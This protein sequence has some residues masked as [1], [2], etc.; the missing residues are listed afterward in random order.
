[1]PS[2]V[3][4]LGCDTVLIYRTWVRWPE[5]TILANLVSPLSTLQ[6][7]LSHQLR[8]VCPLQHTRS[9]QYHCLNSLPATTTE[10]SWLTWVD[11]QHHQTVTA[12]THFRPRARCHL[13]L[14]PQSL[15]ARARGSTLCAWSTFIFQDHVQATN[16][17]CE[18]AGKPPQRQ[19]CSGGILLL[20][21]HNN[22]DRHMVHPFKERTLCDFHRPPI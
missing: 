6:G 8:R 20:W 19:L 13:G 5:H 18:T 4:E 22:P 1:M 14:V 7:L 2:A 11:R 9:T 15:P 21:T 10:Q 3:G 12:P 17:P 16:W